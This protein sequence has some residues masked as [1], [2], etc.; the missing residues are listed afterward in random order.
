MINKFTLF[1]LCFFALN[2]TALAQTIVANKDGNV[3]VDGVKR[4]KIVQT[5]KMNMLT[6]EMPH[7]SIYDVND[8]ERIKFQNSKL[9]FPGTKSFIASDYV[10]DP[11]VKAIANF[12]G[13]DSLFTSAGY[14]K[15]YEE[16]FIKK[17]KGLFDDGNTAS[18]DAKGLVVRDKSKEVDFKGN[19][20][21]QADV[22]IGY[23]ETNKWEDLCK[24][25][26]AKENSEIVAIATYK[27][28]I[29]NAANVDV[30]IEFKDGRKEMQ[31]K[32]YYLA[33]VQK[34]VT[35]ILIKEGYL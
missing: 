15:A 34:E 27:C 32:V 30:T 24:T 26:F 19:V 21:T 14:N 12:F 22:I 1:A 13:Q 6:S 25:K 10:V 16:A 9:L 4:F 28:G 17:H 35:A 5:K 23:V 33:H 18:K 31:L 8:V 29:A 11:R 3:L 7:F 2:F 20:I